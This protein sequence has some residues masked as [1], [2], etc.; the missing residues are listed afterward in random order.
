[1]PA[2]PASTVP[3]ETLVRFGAIGRRLN[4]LS[5]DFANL[6]TELGGWISEQLGFHTAKDGAHFDLICDEFSDAVDA[7]LESESDDA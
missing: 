5:Q 1:M 3:Y 7:R 2:S 4:D 6:D